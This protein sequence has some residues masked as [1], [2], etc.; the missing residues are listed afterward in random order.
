MKAEE[1]QRR[2]RK[3]KSQQK[4]CKDC[5]VQ[6]LDYHFEYEKTTYYLQLETAHK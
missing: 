3:N 1:K 6:R 5:C 4:F 2:A